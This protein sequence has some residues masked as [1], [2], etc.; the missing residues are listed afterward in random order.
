MSVTLDL[1]D[2]LLAVLRAE[3]ERRAT[4]IE[5]LITESVNEHVRAPH[6]HRKFALA[7]VGESDGTRFARDADQ[8]LAD[9]F[10]RD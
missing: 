6:S 8:M 1:P 4:T 7:G 3:A 2:E 9:G 10:G 5:A